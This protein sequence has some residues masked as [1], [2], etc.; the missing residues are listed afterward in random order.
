MKRV[1]LMCAVA[2]LGFSGSAL[3]QLTMQMGNGWSFTVAGN[4][5]AFGVYTSGTV[6]TVGPLSA[7]T[8]SAPSAPLGISGGL[9]PQEKVTR[10]RTGLLPAFVTFDVKGHELGFDLGA[11][12][13]FAPQINSNGSHDNF[14]AQ[15]DMRQVYMTIGGKEWGSVLAGRELG[16]YQRHNI[17][18][19]ITLFGA[20][21]TGGGVGTGGT[22]L[23]RIG[24]GYLYPNFNAQLTYSSPDTLPFQIVVGLFDPSEI[25]GGTAARTFAQTKTPRIETELTFTQPFGEK[26]AA[27]KSTNT[28][29]AWV[30][31]LYQRAETL[32]SVASPAS[33][34]AV[35]GSGGA[36]VDLGGLSLVASGYLGSGIGTTLMFDAANTAVDRA[37]KPRTSWGYMLQ[38]AYAITDTNFVLGGGWGES[39]MV[40]TDNDKTLTDGD[41]LVKANAAAT[42]SV[43]YNWT[44]SLKQVFEFTYAQSEA[45]TGA[46]NKSYQ[47]ALGLMLFF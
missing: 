15:I 29:L 13:G 39:R 30:G 7:A 24:F 11:H 37:D 26:N 6:D 12:F 23:G 10:V 22:T 8:P 21:P 41:P 25:Q 31:G 43:Q 20:G 42:A 3:A 18:T 33:V 47:G 27:G 45:F 32:D 38:A 35:G 5:N 46:K 14:G 36:K 40:E 4:V 1:A 16:L 44:K 28:F 9:V 19:D 34:D 17:L 2:V